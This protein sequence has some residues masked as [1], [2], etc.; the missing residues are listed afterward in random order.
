MILNHP[1]IKM[2]PG[3]EDVNMLCNTLMKLS[4]EPL[5]SCE[6]K[7]LKWSCLFLVAVDLLLPL[8]FSQ[9]TL[10]S[11]DL[12]TYPKFFLNMHLTGIIILICDLI[13]AFMVR[14]L[15][16]F[17]QRN[18]AQPQHNMKNKL[19]LSVLQT[20]IGFARGP[21]LPYVTSFL[22]VSIN[23]FGHNFL[24]LDILGSINTHANV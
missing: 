14:S 8:G 2:C 18:T 12:C 11:P 16:T 9:F 17:I 13:T 20:R 24:L 6:L 5:D 22:G 21:T 7:F 1:S 19:R 15:Y 10:T 4:S 23:L 3:S